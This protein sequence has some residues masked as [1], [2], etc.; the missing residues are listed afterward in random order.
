[1]RRSTETHW[2]DTSYER[3]IMCSYKL[4]RVEAKYWGVQG[5]VE[6]FIHDSALRR[7]MLGAH[8]QAWVWQDEWLGLSLDD[9]RRLEAEAARELQAKFSAPSPENQ[10]QNQNQHQHQ[11]QAL[12]SGAPKEQPPSPP[13]ARD[14]GTEPVNKQQVAASAAAQDGHEGSSVRDSSAHQSPSQ[15][16]APVPSPSPSPSASQTMPVQV[17]APSTSPTA[18]AP[19]SAAAH[20]AASAQASDA[21]LEMSV[22]RSG[23]RGSDADES[24]RRRRTQLLSSSLSISESSALRFCT[25]A[26]F[27][28]DISSVLYTL[29]SFEFRVQ[30]FF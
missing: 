13:R 17:H 11:P 20:A 18:P 24:V 27:I 2:P 22:R 4:C 30:C 7:T 28:T 15:T 25:H 29:G 10:H 23:S 14:R 19:P 5:R 21:G 12:A 9:I 16:Q 3:R 8:R 26:C 1:M 6:R